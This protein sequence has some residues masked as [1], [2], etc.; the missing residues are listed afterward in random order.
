MSMT[1]RAW[2]IAVAA[3]LVAACGGNETTAPD[4]TPTS[5]VTVTYQQLMTAQGWTTRSFTAAEAGVV[6]VTLHSSELPMG[7][8]VGVTSTGGS[9]CQTS[10]SVVTTAGD[11]PQLSTSVDAGDYCLIVFD[12]SAAGSRTT[13]VPVTVVLVHP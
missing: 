2:N 11:S 12:V 1:A 9:G 7:I 3:V 8:G 10:V 4:P 13:Q 6:A 5:P